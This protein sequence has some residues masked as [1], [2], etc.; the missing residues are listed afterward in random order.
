LG[1]EKVNE[2]KIRK[3]ATNKNRMISIVCLI[4]TSAILIESGFCEIIPPSRQVIWQGNAGV[5]GG[6]PIRTNNCQTLTPGGNIQTALNSCPAGQVVYLNSGT[7]TITSTLTIPANVTLRGAGVDS[8]ILLSNSSVDPIVRIGSGYTE[9]VGINITSGYT[10][11]SSQI[12][13]ANAS[14]ISVGDLIRIDELNDATIPVTKEG[15]EGSCTWCGRDNGNRVR[16]QVVKVT[17]KSGNTLNFTP[18]FFFNFSSG[19]IPQIQKLQTTTKY[20]GVEN[21]TIK[22]GSSGGTSGRVNL[23]FYSAENCWVKNIKIDTC[24]KRGIDVRIDNYRIEVRDSYITGCLDAINSDTCYGLQL[25]LS[26]NCLIENNIFYDTTDGPML[27]WGASGNVV[28]YNYLYDVHRDKE[29]DSWFWPDSWTHGAHTSFNLY[30]GN[31]MV[32]FASDFTWGSSS[33]NTFFRNRFLGKHPTFAWVEGT[34][35]TAAFNLGSINNFMN[36][37]GNVLGTS[38]FHDGYEVN[39]PADIPSSKPIYIIGMFNDARPR[40]TVLRHANY[41][42]Y[43]NSTKYCDGSGEPGCQGGDGS[44]TL[45]S[46]LYLSSKPLWWGTLPWPAIGPDLNPMA[47]T[48]PAKERYEGMNIPPSNVPSAPKNLRIQ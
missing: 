41:D 8:T 27:M 43:T 18:A 5:E 26:S 21:L 25:A 42:Y 15:Y 13:V 32:S 44:H 29:L 9:A 10:K 36:L 11:G 48:I 2:M 7:Y 20:A 40:Q 33:H 47:G 30:E 14:T 17:T 24:G 31:I 19:N 28:S 37:V 3:I 12:V 1:E 38:G 22:N 34:L 39:A 46:S 16:A 23:D 45:P 6:I 4:I 35:Q